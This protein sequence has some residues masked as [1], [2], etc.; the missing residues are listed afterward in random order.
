[1]RN[2]FRQI[3]ALSKLA[4]LDLYRRKDLLVALILGAVI[5][6]PLVFFTPFGVGGANRYMDE[7]ALLLIWAFSVVIGVGAASRLFPPEFESRTIFPL[8]SKPVSRGV[9]LLGK[10]L[11][12]LIAAVS[13]LALFYIAYA[14]LTGLRQGAWF[15]LIWLQALLLHAGFMAVAVALALLGSLLLTPSANWTLCLLTLV[16][17]LVFGQ[18]LPELAATQPAPGNWILG[19]I[20]TVAPHCEFFDLRQRMIHGW[21]PIPWLVLLCAELYA[22]LYSAACLALATL[23]FRRHRL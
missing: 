18:R 17:M 1:M 11:G 15:P 7:I 6:F 2:A 4:L 9:L 13:A 10:Y 22:L 21:P 20:Q 5:L 8:L 14:V 12:A 3:S 16:G 19:L 23:A